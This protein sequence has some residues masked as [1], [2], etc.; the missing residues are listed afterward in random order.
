MELEMSPA[1]PHFLAVYFILLDILFNEDIIIK[2][3]E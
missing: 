3:R 2:K 1:N